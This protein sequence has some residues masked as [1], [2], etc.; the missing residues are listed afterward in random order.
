[1]KKKT[2]VSAKTCGGRG[3][4]F[5]FFIYEYPNNILFLFFFFFSFLLQLG[6]GPGL[7]D[8]IHEAI[9]QHLGGGDDAAIEGVEV[10]TAGPVEG[11]AA[12]VRHLAARLLH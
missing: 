4:V 5:F 3:V 2:F 1:M 12:R 10:T 6:G 11:R 7:L 8:G 9:V